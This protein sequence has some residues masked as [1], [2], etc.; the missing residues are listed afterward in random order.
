MLCPFTSFHHHSTSFANASQDQLVQSSG[1]I[2]LVPISTKRSLDLLR[3]A[4][5]LIEP[6]ATKELANAGIVWLF[7]WRF[8]R[9]EAVEVLVDWGRITGAAV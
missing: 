4:V 7:L 9:D 6:V 8:E 1:N 5:F 2:S 3:P